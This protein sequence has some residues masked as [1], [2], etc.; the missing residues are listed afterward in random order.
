MTDQKKHADDLLEVKIQELPEFHLVGF[1]E[2]LAPPLG[3]GIGKLWALLRSHLKESEAEVG[4]RQ[5][6]ASRCKGQS[7]EYFVGIPKSDS[8]Q[9]N[10][11]LVE[12][13][14]GKAEYA[15]IVH[16]G[17]ISKISKTLDFIWKEWLPNSDYESTGE[18]ELEIYDERFSPSSAES[19]MEI[20]IP[21]RR[22]ST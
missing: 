13:K 7:F 4:Q 14:L 5:F 20:G 1:Q 6:A 2:T 12:L 18:F 10:S 16:M 3:P 22:K 19:E 21:V 15:T 11:Q 17:P 9:T 8:A